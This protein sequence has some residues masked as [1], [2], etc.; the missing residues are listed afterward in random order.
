MSKHSCKIH[1][2]A[3]TRP[4]IVKVAPLFRVLR[5][6]PWCSSRLIFVQQHDAPN[7]ST[8]I[9]EDFAISEAT[10]LPLSATGYG[11]RLGEII[12]RY[13]QLCSSDRPDLVVVFGDVDVSMAVALSAKRIGVPVA[14]IEAG[15][16][17]RDMSMPEEINRI[18][19]DS[20][21]DIMLA[22]S[23]D[24][25]NNL[26]FKEGK[27]PESVEFVGNIM[28]DSLQGVLDAGLQARLLSEYGLTARKYAV[29]TFHR[30]AN[31]DT[32][33]ALGRLSDLLTWL[34]ERIPVFFP[35]HPRTARELE[36]SGL[37]AVL[38]AAP[39]VIMTPALRYSSF[40]NLVAASA[41]VLTDSGG[42]QE[43]TSY[44]GIPCLTLRDTT[45]RPI[46]LRLGTNSLANVFDVRIRLENLLAQL[47]LDSEPRPAS[48]PLWD[49]A[50]AY[51]CAAFLSRW[52]RQR[53]P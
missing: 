42:I 32:A 48:I 2:V 34:A 15:L 22:P 47:D 52:W 43:E 36:Q 33:E 31:V 8:E 4:N 41:F 21:A 17:S 30:P 1:L 10:P 28:I 26:V 14:H 18:V 19:I 37:D 13:Q 27:Q 44:L 46:T 12:E 7:M 25:L 20:V 50:A 53:N 5:E 9:F 51:R 39:G 11:P 23:E 24:A 49:G 6:Q 3:G 45:E 29:A 16:R 40:I 35:A 38:R